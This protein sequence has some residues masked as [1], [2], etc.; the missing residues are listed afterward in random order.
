M[1]ATPGSVASRFPLPLVS[2]Y[3]TPVAHAH[4]TQNQEQAQPKGG[5]YDAAEDYTSAAD[6]SMAC[7]PPTD[8]LYKNTLSCTFVTL[9][10]VRR[11]VAYVW[12]R[13]QRGLGGHQPIYLG[14]PWARTFC[15]LS[16][17]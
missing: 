11:S 8:G 6:V 12:K 5:H 10:L 4:G 15:V 7:L 3:T 14:A 2:T 17:F 13:T 16:R 1:L 9:E